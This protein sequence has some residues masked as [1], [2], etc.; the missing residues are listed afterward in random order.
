VVKGL[1]VLFLLTG[2]A[3]TSKFIEL[4]HISSLKDGEPFNE[5]Q[6]SSVD[7]LMG[8]YRYRSNGWTASIAI[9][10]ETSNDLEG[11]N[12]RARIIIG[13]EWESK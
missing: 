9:G 13:K 6:E 2:C 7:L 4:E 10:I 3:N 8:G 1:I 5:N 11:T 12:P